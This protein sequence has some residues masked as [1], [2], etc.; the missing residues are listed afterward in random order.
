MFIISD[1]LMIELLYF[2]EFSCFLL[3]NKLPY[4]GIMF[5]YRDC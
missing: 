2:R 5:E 4:V 1:G 3:R